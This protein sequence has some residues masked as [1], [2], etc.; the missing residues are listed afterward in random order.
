[1][2]NELL[3]YSCPSCGGTL[4]W[5]A[6]EGV[7]KCDFCDS[8]FEE[9]IFKDSKAENADDKIEIDWNVE[10]FLKEHDD[11][12]ICPG[13]IC[14]ACGAQ[15][16][17]DG[18]TAATECMYC[19]NPVVIAANI[20][21]VLKPDLV[22]PFKVTKKEAE[23]IL[24]KFYYDKPLLPSMFK[25]ENTISKITGMYVPFWLYSCT[26]DGTVNFS[27]QKVTSWSDRNYRYTKTRYFAID[28]AGEIS[29]GKIPVDASSKMDDNYM[30][31]LEPYNYSELAPFDSKFMAGFFADKFDVDVAT[32]S[33]RATERVVNSVE[34]SFRDTIVGYSN[35]AKK[36]SDIKMEN[37]EV[38]YALLPVWMLNTKY[39]DKI[40][41]FAINGQTGQIS[42]RLPIDKKK[43]ALWWTGLIAGITLPLTLLI[44]L[45][46]S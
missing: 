35:V 40:Y 12:E 30:D 23:E 24:A 29:F 4:K 34:S 17:S 11:S 9:G 13:Y 37:V 28:R 16:I 22:I 20:E 18:H 1:M 2:D 39:K 5:S 33:G 45:F 15:I 44:R 38:K 6:Q 31:G 46:F 27:A 26:G 21:G 32:C 43:L 41:N 14:D 36:H 25:N 3:T 42:G 19:R 8:E 10:G 7:L